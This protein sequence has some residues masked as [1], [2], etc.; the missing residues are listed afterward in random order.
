MF[1]PC[2]CRGAE[3]SGV[4]GLLRGAFWGVIGVLIRPLDGILDTSARIADSIRTAVMGPPVLA[5]R[6]RPP[7][8]V[9]PSGPLSIYDWSEVCCTLDIQTTAMPVTPWS[10]HMGPRPVAILKDFDTV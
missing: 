6:I 9:D 4:L 5:A 10:M 7:R 3:E 1:L 8:Y 2:C